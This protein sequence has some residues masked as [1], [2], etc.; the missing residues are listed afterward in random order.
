[1]HNIIMHDMHVVVAFPQNM[2]Y[3]KQELLY[4]RRICMHY[5]GLHLYGNNFEDYSLKLYTHRRVGECP[6]VQH[7]QLY[8]YTLF[9]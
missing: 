9:S 1:M 8:I 3:V 2:M 4:K 7:V 5:L 6:S